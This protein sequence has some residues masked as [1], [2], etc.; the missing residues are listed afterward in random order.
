MSDTFHGRDIFAPVAA[1]LSLGIDPAGLGPVMENPVE[2]PTH[3]AVTFGRQWRG[4]VQFVDD[5]GN[6]ITNVPA[7][8]LKS[9]P[10]KVSI[11][12]SRPEVVRWVRTYSEA[13]AG[14]LVCLFS[15]DGYFALA[16]VN[17]SAA[18]RLGV[19]AGAIVLLEWE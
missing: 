2:L 1:H 12:G 19:G 13:P 7:C 14:E 16:E 5:F 9:L 11:D 4:E 6:L 15:S 10:V 8:K 18:R 17:G 3:S